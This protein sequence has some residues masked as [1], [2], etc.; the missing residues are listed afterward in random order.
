MVAYFDK[1]EYPATSWIPLN[2]AESLKDELER[3]GFKPLGARELRDW[4]IEV[5]ED[6][7]AQNTLVVFLQD[8]APDTILDRFT[9]DALVRQYLDHG[10]CI[11]WLGDIPFWYRGKEGEEKPE[12]IYGN[13]VPINLLGVIPVITYTPTDVVEITKE[14]RKLGLT[15]KWTSHRPV[16]YMKDKSHDFIPLAKSK[17]LIAHCVPLTIEGRPVKEVIREPSLLGRILRYFRG[18]FQLGVA[19]VEVR[20]EAERG[21]KRPTVFITGEK[22]PC[23]WIKKFGDG[24]FIRLWDMPIRSELVNYYTRIIATEILRITRRKS[25]K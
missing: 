2:L 13:L 10:G 14:G 20:S 1:H 16:I 15:I 25:L 17:P 8:V 12:P 7:R 5:I 3:E 9:P 23:A 24:M 19:E 21:K 11:L 6:Q 18:R 4:M 22:L